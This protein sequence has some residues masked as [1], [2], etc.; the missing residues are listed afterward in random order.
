MIKHQIVIFLHQTSSRYALNKKSF[1]KKGFNI[2][3]YIKY[4]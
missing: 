2:I 3:K 1:D 4:T